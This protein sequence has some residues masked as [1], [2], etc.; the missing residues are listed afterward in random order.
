MDAMEAP[1][2]HT[3][4]SRPSIHPQT[5]ELSQRHQP[6]LAIGKS[7]DIEIPLSRAQ[8][9]GRN[10]EVPCTRGRFV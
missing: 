6:M 1:G 7:G 2:P 3:G 8:P 4:R 5:F 10:V 9:M